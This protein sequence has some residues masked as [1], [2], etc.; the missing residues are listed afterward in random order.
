MLWS[1]R[2]DF[3]YPWIDPISNGMLCSA[4]AVSNCRPRPETRPNLWRSVPKRADTEPAV[5]EHWISEDL[6]KNSRPR[7]LVS[8]A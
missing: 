1:L 8:A 6:S 7:V 4:Q 2:N 3:L 5:S